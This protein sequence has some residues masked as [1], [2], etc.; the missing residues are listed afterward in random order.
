VKKEPAT[1]AKSSTE[2]KIV[3]PASPNKRI[4][5]KVKDLIDNSVLRPLWI[6]VLNRSKRILEQLDTLGPIVVPTLDGTATES[7]SMWAENGRDFKSRTLNSQVLDPILQVIGTPVKVEDSD[8]SPWNYNAMKDNNVFNLNARQRKYLFEG[9]DAPAR[10]ILLLRSFNK[11]PLIIVQNWMVLDESPNYSPEGHAYKSKTPD[12]TAEDSITIFRGS[13]DK[14]AFRQ[15]M[16]LI[17]RAW[18]NFVAILIQIAT[19]PL[20][21]ANTAKEFRDLVAQNKKI[22]DA[23]A[24]I[25]SGVDK[26]T[27][28]IVLQKMDAG[29][30]GGGSDAAYAVPLINV[31]DAKLIAAEEAFLLGENVAPPEQALIEQLASSGAV[32]PEEIA[33]FA[34]LRSNKRNS[35]RAIAQRMKDF[36]RNQTY[37]LDYDKQGVPTRLNLERIETNLLSEFFAYVARSGLFSREQLKTLRLANENGR[38]YQSISD[39]VISD[40]VL[41]VADMTV[42]ELIDLIH[43][44]APVADVIVLSQDSSP[45]A[46]KAV[47]EAID[48]L[49]EAPSAEPATG[50]GIGSWFDWA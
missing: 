35:I 39:Q 24:N 32:R 23:R 4:D 1:P 13:D 18:A 3:L 7:I 31:V 22:A 43:S 12:T 6:S 26:K 48:A 5:F 34:R 37:V 45:D 14:G 15:R 46:R 36:E 50:K 30:G 19:E 27:G 2:K 40:K 47:K 38:L 20:A 21:S 16:G 44:W 17:G 33:V 8:I 10:E 11:R 29:G 42:Q 28:F 25:K 49:F 41:D 9:S